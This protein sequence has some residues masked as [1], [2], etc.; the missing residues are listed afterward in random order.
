MVHPARPRP[1]GRAILVAAL[2]LPVAT[3]HAQQFTDQT[4]AAFP[5]GLADL[6]TN[7]VDAAD[8]DGDG[9]LDLIFANGGN[10][11]SPGAPQ[12]LRILINDGAGV[13]T[14]QSAARAPGV[15]GAI[16]GVAIG[17]PDDDGDLDLLL[18]EDFNRQPRMLVNDGAGFFTDETATRLPAMTLSSTRAQ[19]G[20][21]DGDGDLDVYINNGG[22]SNRFGCGQNR[23]WIN[24]GTGVFTDETEA[25]HPLGAV[26]QPMDVILG[27]LDG[28][29]DLDVRTGNR[30]TGNSIVYRNDGGVLV[31]VPEATPPD[32][33]CYSYDLG[34]MDGDGDLDMIGANGGP[35]N[36]ENLLRNDG[37]LV[38]TD[39]SS[40]L[41]PNTTGDDNDSKFVDLDG[42]NDLDLIVAALYQS[43]EKVYINNGSGLFQLDT[44]RIS[45]INDATLDLVLAD[46]D[47]DGDY[48]LV[49][50][51]GESGS[52]RDR[53]YRNGGPA[54]V[55]PPAVRAETPCARVAG[56]LVI[57]AS[58][59]DA[60]TSDR[61]CLP[62]SVTLAWS[63][64]GGPET[65]TPMRW[66][67][68]DLWR[69]AVPAPGPGSA[70]AYRVQ[71]VDQVGNAGQGAE[72]V[73]VIRDPALDLDGDC[74]V[75]IT[76][77]LAVLAAWGPCPD[78]PEDLDGDGQAGLLDLLRLLAD[79][80]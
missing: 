1:F 7:A 75:G 37:N 9:D 15:S 22:S 58:V 40:R 76:D 80:D 39:V 49:T 62:R 55:R 29:F 65:L 71:A 72:Q 42:D 12:P 78:C 21:L 4:T 64:D 79:W 46:F 44:T 6:Y 14:D 60:L 20:D 63:V 26:C 25:R 10:F 59:R 27:D 45:S 51:Q 66:I 35:S 70:V 28:D 23:V 52:Y 31:A 30:G 74:R 5:S 77:L 34:D 16:R 69:A 68:H 57:R 8:L 33:N 24:D 17:D 38:F 43:R 54:D 41:Q 73:L 3:V 56:E 36:R 67:G 61:G 18:S 53:Y 11:S 2:G 47:G 13:F 32:S 50:G 48:D 19:F